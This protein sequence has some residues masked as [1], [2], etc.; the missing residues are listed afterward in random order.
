MVVACVFIAALPPPTPPRARAHARACLSHICC[1]P[2]SNEYHL[3]R[4]SMVHKLSET[5]SLLSPLRQLQASWGY[6]HVPYPYAC[7]NDEGKKFQASS[8]LYFGVCRGTV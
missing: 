1:A 5:V 4:V 2:D 8:G 3:T 6:E 7:C